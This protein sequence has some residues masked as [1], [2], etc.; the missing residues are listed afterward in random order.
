LYFQLCNSIYKV[1]IT[2]FILS[3]LTDNRFTSYFGISLRNTSKELEPFNDQNRSH[4]VVLCKSIQ[5]F[6]LASFF[7]K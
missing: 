7:K 3:W 2:G 1:I 5:R 6:V 4:V